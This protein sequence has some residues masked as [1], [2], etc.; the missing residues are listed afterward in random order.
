M[1]KYCSVCFL[2]FEGAQCPVCGRKSARQTGPDDLCFLTE[3][4]AIW[5][6]ML[7][8]ALGQRGIPF[9]QKNRLGAGLAI[10]IGPMRERTRFYVRYAQLGEAK[11]TVDALFPAEEDAE[12]EDEE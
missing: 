10:K 4:E 8:D 7:A 3:K 5:S 11:E 12:D 1:P 2:P 9:L 6:G